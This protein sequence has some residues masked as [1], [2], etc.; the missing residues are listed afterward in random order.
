MSDSPDDDPLDFTPVPSATRRRDGWTEAR[1][2]AFIA[3]LAR[4][5]SV[6][7]SA[8]QVGKSRRGA[9]TL[10]ERPGAESFSEAWDVAAE[11]GA[12][13]TRDCVIDRAMHGAWVP[14]VRRGRI[15]RMEFRYFD[16]LAIGILAG[17]GRDIEENRA[18]RERI[19]AYRRAVR[20]EDRRRREVDEA[21][22]K[23]EEQVAREQEEKREKERLARQTP[24]RI[25]LI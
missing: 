21:H 16:K 4:C 23:L 12:E 20:E 7:A 2:R 3:A 13:A 18:E 22:R 5:G 6:S 19:R 14:I 25:R 11:M 1:Q 10:R 24:P 15:V 8:R 9:Y 17:R